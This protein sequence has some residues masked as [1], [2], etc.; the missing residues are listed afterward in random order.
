[1]NVMTGG[2]LGET[3]RTLGARQGAASVRSDARGIVDPGRGLRAFELRRIEPAQ[4]DVRAVV[5]HYWIVSWDL[6]DGVVHDQAVL[7]HPVVNV[8]IRDGEGSVVGP[9][10]KLDTRQLSGNGWAFG[11]MFRPGAFRPFAGRALNMITDSVLTLAQVFE[12]D[13]ANAFVDAINHA[14]SDEHRGALADAF[15]HQRL[16]TA[17]QPSAAAVELVELIARDRTIIR[18]DDVAKC[19]GLSLRQ[20]QRLFAEHVGLPP[21]VVIRRYR[22]FEVA[23]VARRGSGRVLPWA[24]LAADLGYSDH[25]HLIRDFTTTIGMSPDQYA[26]RQHLHRD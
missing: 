6:P 1:M 8:V 14:D 26:K 4:T 20:L 11:T 13:D 22:L 7:P 19:A 5:D 24:E 10:S 9:Q 2:R 3:R 25:S 12:D 18:A 23:E 17:A 15:V 21:K 16:A